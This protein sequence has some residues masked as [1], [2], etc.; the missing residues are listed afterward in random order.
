MYSCC[1]GLWIGESDPTDRNTRFEVWVARRHSLQPR[2]YVK[3][4][5]PRWGLWIKVVCESQCP[6]GGGLGSSDRETGDLQA[7]ER[8]GNSGSRYEKYR[9]DPDRG[10]DVLGDD[11]RH[12]E[13][14]RSHYQ[15]GFEHVLRDE[16][17]ELGISS[18]LG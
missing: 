1:S 3:C 9:H 17:D 18:D 2:F 5:M 7:E 13:G 16:A 15:C 8:G 6:V 4:R 11:L 14:E 10:V 12:R